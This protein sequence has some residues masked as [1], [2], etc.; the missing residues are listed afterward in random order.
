MN[1]ESLVLTRYLYNKSKVLDKLEECILNGREDEAYFW[2]YE[3]Y[4]SF[5]ETE[6]FERFFAILKVNYSGFPRLY[7]YLFERYSE[8]K[9]EWDK[10]VQ[11]GIT[12]LTIDNVP[13]NN[14]HMIIPVFI[15]NIIIRNREKKEPKVQFYI[16]IPMDIEFLIIYKTKF[17]TPARKT[18]QINCKYSLFDTT[19]SNNKELLK[20]FTD[21]WLYYASRS[22]IWRERIYNY[23]GEI[24][25]EEKMIIFENDDL[26]EDFYEN[27]GFE[28]DEQTIEIQRGCIGV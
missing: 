26:L 28:L 4:F 18:L 21:H 25:H 20:E 12:T 9:I 8:W 22:P 19:N 13:N 6:L 7:K 27:F 24:D 1:T 10:S 5:L 23:S 14:L 16:K 17:I 2:A 15:K 3:I 11:S